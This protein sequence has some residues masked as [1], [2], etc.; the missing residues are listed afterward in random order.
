MG[1]AVAISGQIDTAILS[2]E[3]APFEDRPDRR[4]QPGRLHPDRSAVITRRITALALAFGVVIALGKAWLYAHT[5]SVG[6]LSS[7]V[8]SAVDIFAASAS[9]I[10]VRIAARTPTHH[11]RFGF[12]KA[13]SFAA[14]LQVCLIGLAALHL[15]GAAF[16]EL[17]HAHEI[18][19]S[20]TAILVMGL[21]VLM[22]VWLLIAQTWAIRAT[23][24]I[25]VRG[26]R[27]HYLADA[28]GNIFVLAGLTIA[29]VTGAHWADAVVGLIMAAWLLYTGWRVAKLAWDQLM[30]RELRDDERQDIID[31]V[32]TD[33][34]VRSVTNLRSRAAGPNL[35]MQ[36]RLDLDP[37]LSLSDAHDILIDA[38]ARL[39]AI[40][41]SAD[42]LIHPHPAGCA[43]AHGNIRFYAD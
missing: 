27:A 11:Y 17:D 13:E 9:F 20:G 6:V 4:G 14:V 7:L 19:G 5:G 31:R 29:T 12:G 34:R 10:A 15:F 25:A 38:E 23:G 41:P 8:H 18:E 35:H 21:F 3:M 32:M 26:D 30:D 33:P 42:I 22:T 37:E 40:Y 36:M 16:G 43:Q 28:F 39:M 1:R 2:A 24:S